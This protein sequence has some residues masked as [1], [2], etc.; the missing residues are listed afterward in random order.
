MYN[1]GLSYLNDDSVDK[2]YNEAFELFKQSAE[3]ECSRGIT[4]LGYCY[5]N[6]IGTDVDKQKA[7]ELYRKAANLGNSIA[8]YNIA[9]M[10]ENGEGI[11]KDINQAIY[12]YEQSAKQGHQYAQN[13]L[14]NISPEKY[15]SIIVNAIVAFIFKG[16]NEGKGS[17]KQYTLN[18]FSDHNLL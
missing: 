5:G 17:S 18:Y 13:R 4:R 10:Y 8:Q 11:E 1:L 9:L 14:K 16:L 3:E 15:L 12:W 6:G 2:N 7:V